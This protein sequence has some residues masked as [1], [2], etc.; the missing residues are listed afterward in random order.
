MSC[1]CYVGAIAV[2]YAESGTVSASPCS[3]HSD[4]EGYYDISGTYVPPGSGH[5]DR[6]FG[7]R[8]TTHY[9]TNG[10]Y[11]TSSDLGTSI[12]I[13]SGLS[14]P[15]EITDT[16]YDPSFDYGVSLS[17]ASRDEFF[18]PVLASDILSYALAHVTYGDWQPRLTLSPTGGAVFYQPALDVVGAQEANTNYDY[19]N[20]DYSI[21]NGPNTVTSAS[22]KKIKFRFSLAGPKLPVKVKYDLYNATDSVDVSTDNEFTLDDGTPEQ[23]VELPLTSDKEI[24]IQNIRFWFDPFHL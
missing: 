12:S 6:V 16:N 4:N 1:Q 24:R 7:K 9:G 11:W 23:E 2:E 19:G 10:N 20:T 17:P 14:C 13:D 3:F 8:K 18:N 21:L 22:V 5:N 15:A